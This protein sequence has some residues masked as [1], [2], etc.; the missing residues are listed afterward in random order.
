MMQGLLNTS[1]QALRLWE[2]AH[3]AFST[4]LEGQDRCSAIA[5]AT[6][7]TGEASFSPSPS[8]L[9]LKLWGHC[10]P[11]EILHS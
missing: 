4:T 7:G 3:R 9:K 2:I 6:L 10:S 1:E 11:Y 8:F 5:G